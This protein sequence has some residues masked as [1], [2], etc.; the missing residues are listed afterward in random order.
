MRGKCIDL[1]KTQT[2]IAL[3]EDGYSRDRCDE[4]RSKKCVEVLHSV[5]FLVLSQCIEVRAGAER[6]MVE[7]FGLASD[8]CS[9]KLKECITALSA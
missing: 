4:G 1:S 6:R 9:L 2:A 3:D 5:S 7:A 8:S